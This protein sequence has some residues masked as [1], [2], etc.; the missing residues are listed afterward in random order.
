M[1][2]AQWLEPSPRSLLQRALRLGAAGGKALNDD[3][4]RAG[5]GR[6]NLNLDYLYTPAN[7]K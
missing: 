7:A 5:D 4:L 2:D 3:T 1:K 6:R